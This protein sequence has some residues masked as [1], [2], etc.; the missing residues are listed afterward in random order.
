MAECGVRS[1]GASANPARASAKPDP[2]KG[3]ARMIRTRF[4]YLLA[5]LH[6]GP[7]SGG[8]SDRTPDPRRSRT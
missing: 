7:T 8:S 3:G 2:A 1:T 6:L 4:P 5:R